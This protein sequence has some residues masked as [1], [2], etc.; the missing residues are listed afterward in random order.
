MP[1]TAEG[2]C[3]GAMCVGDHPPIA[4]ELHDT[5]GLIAELSLIGARRYIFGSAKRKWSPYQYVEDNRGEGD[6]KPFDPSRTGFCPYWFLNAAGYINQPDL[7]SGTF[8]D[9]ERSARLALV[10]G[11]KLKAVVTNPRFFKKTP[12]STADVLYQK[13]LTRERGIVA[14][15]GRKLYEELIAALTRG[16]HA[17]AE[18]SDS[19]P[20]SSRPRPSTQAAAPPPVRPEPT[21]PPIPARPHQAPTVHHTGRHEDDIHL[22]LEATRKRLQQLEKEHMEAKNRRLSLA[23]I[24]HTPSATPATAGGGG[25]AAQGGTAHDQHTIWYHLAQL[26]AIEAPEH[27]RRTNSQIANAII[28]GMVREFFFFHRI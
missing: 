9:A 14:I 1:R 10:S 18:F 3:D 16:T 25:G 21:P 20:L 7:P 23:A 2:G 22:E 19:C 6:L 11:D 8:A 24:P 12:V 5:G 4:D 27:L 13:I 15:Q 28:E 17:S 26:R